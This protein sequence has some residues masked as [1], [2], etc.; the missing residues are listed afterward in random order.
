MF[1]ID[2]KQTVAEF[3]LVDDGEAHSRFHPADRVLLLA[4]IFKQGPELLDE[5]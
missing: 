1:K 2:R 5:D 4:V 3:F